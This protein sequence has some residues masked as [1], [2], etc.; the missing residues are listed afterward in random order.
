MNPNDPN[1]D[2]LDSSLESPS[3]FDG[4]I[5]NTTG[6]TAAGPAS[7][8]I[9][10]AAVTPGS[11]APPPHSPR[12]LL[13][14]SSTKVLAGL[15][16]VALLGLTSYTLI[17]SFRKP[18]PAPPQ[19]IINTQNLDN[20]TLS[21]VTQQAGPDATARQ[22]LTVSPDVLFKNSSHIQGSSQVDGDLNVGGNLSVNGTATFQ[23]AVGV[24][25]NLAVRGNL[26]VAGSLNVGS[27][28]VGSLT[29]SSLTL[30]NSF[31]FSGHLIPGGALPTAKISVAGG[32][33]TVAIDGN[34]IS[35]TVTITSGGGSMIAGEMAIISFHTNYSGTPKVQLTPVNANAANLRYYVTRTAGFFTVNNTAPAAN[36]TAYVFDYFVT[37]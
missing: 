26:S 24:N 19:I 18:K 21:K 32:G 33:G 35:G 8:L 6:P 22:Q 3:T 27:I 25:S 17:S 16:A 12:K 30:G 28:N 37:Q 36:N 15:L 34:D 9:D 1:R 7:G 4:Q 14:F 20:G 31:S 11:P 29:A 13:S 10:P 23:K 5:N 2:S